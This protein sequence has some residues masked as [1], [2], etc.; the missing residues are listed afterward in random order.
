MKFQTVFYG[1]IILAATND[2]SI[3]LL[4]IR[5]ERQRRVTFI[6]YVLYFPIRHLMKS[7][8]YLPT[9]LMH[10]EAVSLHYCRLAVAVDDKSWKVVTL[11][12]HQSE[13]GILVFSLLSAYN[14]NTF[15]HTIG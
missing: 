14:A 8:G 5:L 2:K 9:T 3:V 13:C 10:S 12:M 7:L 1:N 4:Y 6:V 15:S 11:A